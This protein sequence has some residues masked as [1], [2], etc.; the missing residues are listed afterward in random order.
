MPDLAS[1]IATDTK[2]RPQ[3]KYRIFEDVT[4]WMTN[5]GHPGYA[6]AAIDELFTNSTVTKRFAESARG[7]MSPAD[8]M[9]AADAEV[10]ETFA[11]WRALGKV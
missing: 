4:D 5:V 2:A 1:L 7:Q 10:R 3:D 9:N 11:R 8:A 6:N